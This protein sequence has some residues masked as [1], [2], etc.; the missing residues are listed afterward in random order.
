MSQI[1]G[2][3]TPSRCSQLLPRYEWCDSTVLSS[4]EKITRYALV[5]ATD[6][7]QFPEGSVITM[8]IPLFSWLLRIHFDT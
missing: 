2:P 1:V 4:S 3:L 5:S 7:I 8:R 6:S